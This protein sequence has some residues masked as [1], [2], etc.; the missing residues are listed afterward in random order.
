MILAPETPLTSNE[1]QDEASVC[2]KY[3]LAAVARPL[4]RPLP[5]PLQLDLLVAVGE[6]Q[7]AGHTDYE[8]SYMTQVKPLLPKILFSAPLSAPI[9]APAP[10]TLKMTFLELSISRYFFSYIDAWIVIIKFAKT[11]WATMI[12]PI[13]FFQVYDIKNS[14]LCQFYRGRGT[15]RIGWRTGS[16]SRQGEPGAARSVAQATVSSSE[17]QARQLPGGGKEL[18]KLRSSGS[19]WAWPTQH[20]SKTAYLLSVLCLRIRN[21]NFWSDRDPK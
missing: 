5:R 2:W 16:G 6:W 19:Y 13:T 3:L 4:T 15:R 11:S 21:W 1:Y 18:Q 17:T 10:D 20:V 12:Y 9:P 8:M 7:Q 14:I